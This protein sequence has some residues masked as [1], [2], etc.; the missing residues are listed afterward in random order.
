MISATEKKRV[1][2]IGGGFTGLTAAY[3]LSKNPALEITVIERGNQLGGL[4]ADFVLQGTHIEK[5]YHHLFRSDVAILRLVEELDLQEKMIWC[6]SSLGIFYEGKTHPFMSP[7]D[8]LRFKPLNFLNRIRLGAVAFYLQKEKNWRKFIN[9]TAYNWM[10]RACGAQC[11]K[12]VWEPLLKGKFDRYFDS[13]SMAWLWARIHIR[14]NSRQSAGRE[15]LGYFKGGF[16]VVTQKL[17]DELA[18]RGVKI[19]K[20]STVDQIQTSD[21]QVSLMSDGETKSFDK[22]IF[23][24]PSSAFA[25]LISAQPK[26][27]A[28]VKRL[29]S[30]SYLGAICLVFASEQDIGDYYWLN[31]NQVGAPFLVFINHTKMVDKQFYN[32]KNVYYIGSYQPHDSATFSMSDEEIINR[33]LDFLQ[34]IYPEFDR[35]QILEKHLFKFKHAQHIVDAS[36]ESKIPEYKTPLPNVYLANFSQIFPEDRGTNYAVREGVKIAEL[37]LREL[38]QTV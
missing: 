30:I 8:V 36:Y 6:E 38:N 10:C 3:E 25:K 12:V 14:A 22:C 33:W 26:L 16:A 1:A 15:K 20:N 37:L 7:R 4:A 24:G 2:I 11:V 17:E 19:V 18:K 23:T 13:V 5:T 32:S 28:Y 31:I 27:D 9:H 21:G 35:S 29:E 34:K